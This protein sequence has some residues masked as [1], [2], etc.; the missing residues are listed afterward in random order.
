MWGTSSLSLLSGPL[1]PGVVILV[2]VT[3][4]GQIELL[5]FFTRV[6]IIDYFK[7]Y[8]L[9]KLFVLDRNTLLI[10]LLMLKSTTWNYFTVCKQMFNIINCEKTSNVKRQYLE[11]FNCVQTNKWFATNLMYTYI[12]ICVCVHVRENLASNN[13][14]RLICH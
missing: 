3:S 11:P 8:S 13:P 10:E 14:Q 4:K 2:K 5:N 12:C 9:C 6:T 7:L 1:Q